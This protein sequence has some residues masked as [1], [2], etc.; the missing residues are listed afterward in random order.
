M[1]GWDDMSG[2]KANLPG[3]GSANATV[4]GTTATDAVPVVSNAAPERTQNLEPWGKKFEYTYEEVGERNW[5]G[6]ARVYEWDGEMGE[7]G[8]EHPELE[9]ILFGHEKDRSPQG[10]DFKE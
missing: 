5:D 2:L 4:A 3:G 10:V 7:I 8:P 6:N 1:S 9:K